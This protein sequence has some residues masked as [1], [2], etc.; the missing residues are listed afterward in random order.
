MTFSTPILSSQGPFII[1]DAVDEVLTEDD[2]LVADE[3]ADEEVEDI[4]DDA[5]EEDA[6]AAKL[7]GD[8]TI[9]VEIAARS[10]RD[11]FIGKIG[12]I[13]LEMPSHRHAP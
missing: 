13:M 1:V 4:T 3:T 9:S 11:F 2:E 12:E 10:E 7:I 6:S 5:E 8:A